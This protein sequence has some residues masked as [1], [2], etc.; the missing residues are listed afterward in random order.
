MTSILLL[1]IY[2]N[3][4][5]FKIFE[6]TVS[7]LNVNSNIKFQCISQLLVAAFDFKMSVLNDTNTDLTNI[8]LIIS[9]NK[10]RTIFNTVIITV[11]RNKQY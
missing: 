9:S 6:N 2:L 7:D 1:K 3:F 10:F 11:S 4:N 5:Q 8:K